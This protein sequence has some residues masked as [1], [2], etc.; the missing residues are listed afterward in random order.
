MPAECCVQEDFSDRVRRDRTLHGRGQVDL[1]EG[2]ADGTTGLEPSDTQ[3]L[4]F[5][6]SAL[7]MLSVIAVAAQTADLRSTPA[8]LAVAIVFGVL[9]KL[10]EWFSKAEAVVTVRD[11][12]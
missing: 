7:I 5:L 6:V 2:M 3:L 8:G 12:R 10:G 9:F 1:G 4:T 11:G